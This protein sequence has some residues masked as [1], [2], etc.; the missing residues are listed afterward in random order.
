MARRVGITEA[1]RVELGAPGVEQSLPVATKAPGRVPEAGRTTIADLREFLEVP[2]PVLEEQIQRIYFNLGSPLTLTAGSTVRPGQ[3]TGEAIPRW[4]KRNDSL[5]AGDFNFY[6]TQANIIRPAQ[7]GIYAVTLDIRA[8]KDE[9]DWEQEPE[10]LPLLTAWVPITRS[11]EL[12]PS[13]KIYGPPWYSIPDG[14]AGVVPICSQTVIGL[15]TGNRSVNFHFSALNIGNT[16]PGSR[17]ETWRWSRDDD[18]N[19]SS[20]TFQLIQTT[21]TAQYLLGRRLSKANKRG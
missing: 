2:E 10:E 12:T 16:T 13:N 9:G 15:V 7:D 5:L 20:V 1:P 19:L 4:E 11:I 8:R 18:S 17:G 14:T 6:Q 3:T 21:E